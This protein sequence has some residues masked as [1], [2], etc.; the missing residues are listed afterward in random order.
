MAGWKVPLPKCLPLGGG[1]G[2][3]GGIVSHTP[4]PLPP[5]TA[6]VPSLVEVEVGGQHLYF[7]GL[8]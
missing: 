2:G 4:G 5:P 7:G 8:E 6:G 3:Y 1:E